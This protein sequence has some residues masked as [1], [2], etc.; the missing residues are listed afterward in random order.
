MIQVAENR[1]PYV[2]FET[3]A[4]EDRN[5]SIEAGHYVAKDVDYVL[6]TPMGSKDQIERVASEWFDYLAQDSNGARFPQEWVKAFKSAYAEWKQGNELPIDGTPVKTWPIPS[7][8]QIKMMLNWH[9]RT[10][11]DLA[12][13]NEE[14]ISRLG[15][16]ARALKQQAIEWLASSAG[17]GKVSA[18]ISALKAQNADLKARNESLEKRIAALEVPSRKA[19]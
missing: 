9:I 1:P 17:T 12:G 2:M 10:V 18:E 6:I 16:G 15:M 13:A 4:E 8:A 11:E 7:P 19:A 14:T 5:A 3:R